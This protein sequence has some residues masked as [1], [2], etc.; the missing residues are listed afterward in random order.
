MPHVQGLMR[1]GAT[2]ANAIVSNPL[3]CPSRATILTGLY[4]GHTGVWTNAGSNFGGWQ[5]FKTA[6]LTS[7]GTLFRGTGDN[8]GRTLPLYLQ[9]HGYLTGLY[10]KY[11]N[12]YGGGGE[13]PRRS[14]RDGRWMSFLGNNGA[15]YDY[16]MSDRGRSCDHGVAPRDYSTDVF[17]RSAHGFLQ[18]PRRPARHDPSS[19]TTRRSPRTAR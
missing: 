5:S 12:H 15:Y 17:G 4:A 19:S 11:L 7:S 14:R 3:C 1:R 13:S 8:E 9:R 2:F 6:G 16:R 18:T 10:G